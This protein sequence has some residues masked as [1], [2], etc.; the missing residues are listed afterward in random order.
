VG[1][2]LPLVRQPGQAAR[3]QLSFG[4]RLVRGRGPRHAP[5]RFFTPVETVS[6]PRR[7]GT[8]EL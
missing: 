8:R 4:P 3:W 2:G 6:P 5:G 7:E 1:D